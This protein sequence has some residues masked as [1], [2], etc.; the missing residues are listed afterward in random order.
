MYLDQMC[1]SEK[2]IAI[3]LGRHLYRRKFQANFS[4]SKNKI[5]ST[6]GTKINNIQTCMQQLHVEAALA[7]EE[8]VSPP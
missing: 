1:I 6:H 2:Q 4:V 8:H 7:F 3:H 5:I